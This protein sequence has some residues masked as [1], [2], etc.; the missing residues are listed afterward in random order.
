MVPF[1]G[2]AK[3]RD[4]IMRYEL[5]HESKREPKYHVLVTTYEIATNSR[6]FTPVFKS[7]GRW[8]ILVVDEGQR[9]ECFSN[10]LG[11]AED[12]DFISVSS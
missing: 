6:D 10:C 4:V 2:E 12:L 1:L 11:S 8:E 7:V 9:R 3:S 5:F